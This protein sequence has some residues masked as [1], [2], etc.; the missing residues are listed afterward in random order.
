MCICATIASG[1]FSIPLKSAPEILALLSEVYFR[2]NLLPFDIFLPFLKQENP[3]LRTYFLV[4]AA[5]YAGARKDKNV[6]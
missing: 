4:T 5:I 3:K 6:S 1:L 2:K